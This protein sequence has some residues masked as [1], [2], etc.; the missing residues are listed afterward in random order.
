[1]A[2]QLGGAGGQRG[3]ARRRSSRGPVGGARRGIAMLLKRRGPLPVLALALGLVGVP[4][5]VA[6]AQTPRDVA[7]RYAA[8]NAARARRDARGRRRPRRDERVPQRA[9]RRHA[10]QRQPAPRGPRGLRAATRRSTSAATAASCSPAGSL[11]RGL[12]G[13]R[14]RALSSTR[15]TR[16]RPRPTGSTSR[17]PA[18]LRVLRARRRPARRTVVSD[19]RD[20]GRA[21]PGRAGLLSRPRTACAWRGRSR[22]TTPRTGTCG[23]RRS[24]PRAASCCARATGARTPRRRTRS[25]TGRATAC[26]SSRSRTRTT[27]SARW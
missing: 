4:E 12:D 15:S 13:D 7:L 21:D 19:G 20:L 5:G 1:M 6:A 18:G 24:T 16:S 26:S 17:R 23:R 27:A 8:D 11:V 22:S 14:R 25:T 2:P 10:R 9:Q 3:P